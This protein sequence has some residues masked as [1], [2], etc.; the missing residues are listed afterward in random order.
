MLWGKMVNA[1]NWILYAILISMW[2]YDCHH[3]IPV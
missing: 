3:E 1:G 2:I